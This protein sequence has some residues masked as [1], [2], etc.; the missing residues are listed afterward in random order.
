MDF[1]KKEFWGKSCLCRRTRRLSVRGKIRK[2][3][4]RPLCRWDSHASECE[5]VVGSD[6]YSKTWFMPDCTGGAEQCVHRAKHRPIVAAVYTLRSSQ[7]YSDI[8]KFIWR[9]LKDK[10]WIVGY[11]KSLIFYGRGEDFSA[12]WQKLF[13]MY[14]ILVKFCKN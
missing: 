5:Q 1:V 12:G 2:G 13:I 6:C 10:G 3:N 4:E 11:G 14:R 8:Y 9:Q 7:Y